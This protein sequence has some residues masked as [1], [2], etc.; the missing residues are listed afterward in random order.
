MFSDEYQMEIDCE[1]VERHEN[2]QP[3]IRDEEILDS[4]KTHILQKA[5]RI[6]LRMLSRWGYLI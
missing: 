1:T 6:H 3:Y 5:A 4:I 2:Y